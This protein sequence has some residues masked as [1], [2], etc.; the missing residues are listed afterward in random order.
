MCCTV[1]IKFSFRIFIA[2]KTTFAWEYAFCFLLTIVTFIIIVLKCFCT[3][4]K[5]ESADQEQT[6]HAS[7]INRTNRPWS[8][9]TSSTNQTLSSPGWA[10][11]HTLT[12]PWPPNQPLSVTIS[13][14]NQMP[15]P[16]PD[17]LPP[18]Y[19]ASYMPHC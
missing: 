13:S 19:D 3:K 17:D 16:R 15:S 10:A 8:L 6:A 11:N 14:A 1:L 5:A 9:S 12:P 4:D 18:S 7:H 2:M